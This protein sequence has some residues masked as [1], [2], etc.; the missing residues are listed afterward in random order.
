VTGI[1][2]NF[3]GIILKVSDIILNVTSII[4]KVPAIVLKVFGVVLIFLMTVLNVS[5]G[6][7]QIFLALS[8]KTIYINCHTATGLVE[9]SP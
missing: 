8:L 1:I 2:L 6:V 5:R 9:I 4:L 7:H 3:T